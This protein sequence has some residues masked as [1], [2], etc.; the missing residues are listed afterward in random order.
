MRRLLLVCALVLSAAPAFAQGNNVHIVDWPI[1]ATLADNTAVPKTPIIGAVCMV[2]D[3]SASNVDFC[4]PSV[5]ASHGSTAPTTGPEQ[6]LE[7]TSSVAG[8]TNVTAG[9]STRSKAD[10]S[11]VALVRPY[12]NP[13]DT[14]ACTPVGITNTTS[15]AVCASAGSGL[16]NYITTIE[17]TNSSSTNLTVNIQDGA[18]GSVL[19][20]M[21]CPALGGSVRE[22]PMPLRGSSNTA[23]AFQPSTG[24]STVTMS[25]IGFKSKL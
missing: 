10:L 12:A 13:E 22:F 1:P 7:A 8:A 21:S 3:T 11:G 19:W 25:M 20:T 24:A 14:I 15:T 17:C 2:K 16:R 5:D 4:V 18:G 23:V 9:Q 6:L